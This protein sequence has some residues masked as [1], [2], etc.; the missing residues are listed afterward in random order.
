MSDDL[1]GTIR[2]IDSD[3]TTHIP[4][5]PVHT[6]QHTF[7]THSVKKGTKLDVVRK[8]LGHASLTTTSISVDLARAVMDEE[9]QK[10]A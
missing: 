10:N 3:D 2:R 7:A 1:T 9:M 8:A 4:R 6:L 5:A